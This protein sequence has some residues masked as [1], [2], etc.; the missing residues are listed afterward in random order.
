M[1]VNDT[2]RFN[3]LQKIAVEESPS[4][5]PLLFALDVIHGYRTTFPV[6][7]AEALIVDLLLLGVFAVQHSVMAR[8]WFKEWWTRWVPKIVERS[9]YVLFASLALIALFAYWQPIGGV[10]WDVQNPVGQAVL[11]GLCALGWGLVLVATF[12]INH[13]DLF[14]LRQVWLQFI[15]RPYTKLPFATPG[16]YRLVDVFAHGGSGTGMAAAPHDVAPL[17]T[18]ASASA[19]PSSCSEYGA[20]WARARS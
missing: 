10:I 16:P 13:F 20:P 7:L 3:E 2:Q 14:G 12:L 18:L 1:W 5:I 17:V 11:Y 4:G 6:P 19:S 15:G 8:P 9:T